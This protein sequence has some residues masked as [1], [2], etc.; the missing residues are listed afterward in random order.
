MWWCF[1]FLRLSIAEKT[2]NQVFRVLRFLPCL[3]VG[4]IVIFSLK[5]FGLWFWL[6]SSHRLMLG[7]LLIWW[8]FRFLSLST[9]E[10]NQNQVFRVLVF[11]TGTRLVKIATFS[12]KTFGLWF[13]LKSSHRFI[14]GPSSMWWSLTFLRLFI[15]EKTHNQV[16]RVLQFLPGPRL[17]K[18]ATFSLK[19]FGLWFWLK[20][21]HRLMLGPLLMWWSLTFF[22]LF[23]AEKTHNQVFRVL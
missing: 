20:S 3:C 9:A 8:S 17:G 5:N 19:T 23:I 11:S 2:H 13:W 21:S 4:K 15:A 7:P 22:R 6:K 12:L 1:T 18:I 10:K 16:F 14:L